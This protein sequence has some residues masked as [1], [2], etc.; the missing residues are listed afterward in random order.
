MRYPLGFRPSCQEANDAAREAAQMTGL[1]YRV[2][3]AWDAAPEVGVYEA[4][5]FAPVDPPKQ[6]DG[7]LGVRV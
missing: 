7:H 6:E 5:T 1:R 4:W 3:K 2:R